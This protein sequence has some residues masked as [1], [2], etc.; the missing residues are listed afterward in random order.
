MIHRCHSYE[1][2]K[3]SFVSSWAA[4]QYYNLATEATHSVTSVTLKVTR[5]YRTKAG[6]FAYQSINCKR[7]KKF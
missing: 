2:Q 4:L 5:E 1:K 3:Q 6:N 7:W